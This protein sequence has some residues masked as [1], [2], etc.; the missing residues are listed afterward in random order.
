MS[1]PFPGYSF[2]F[3]IDTPA[4]A[5]GDPMA[6][7]QEV[8]GLPK[9]AIAEY[10]SDPGSPQTAHHHQR[11][12]GPVKLLRG[13]IIAT[14]FAAWATAARTG[15]PYFAAKAVVV[16]HGESREIVVSWT[17]HRPRLVS[18]NGSVFAGKGAGE[19][20]PFEM[21]GLV[22]DSISVD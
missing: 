3:S 21:I 1:N 7:C 17:L 8:W 22:V 5:P 9:L 2:L 4:G 11:G 10:R 14:Q 19:L 15:R 13:M 12:A 6:G 20:V 18:T 16:L